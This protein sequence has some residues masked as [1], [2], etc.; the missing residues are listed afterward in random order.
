MSIIKNLRELYSTKRIE[1]IEIFFSL[2]LLILSVPVF[3]FYNLFPT[4][5]PEIGPHQIASWLSVTLA[6]IG[7]GTLIYNMGKLEI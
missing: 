5:S 3:I 4:I 2:I 7:F 6:F 1:I